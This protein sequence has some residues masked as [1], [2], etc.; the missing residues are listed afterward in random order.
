M[1][2]IPG[3][4]KIAL[5]KSEEEFNTS[6]SKAQGISFFFSYILFVCISLLF[7]LILTALLIGYI[8]VQIHCN[9]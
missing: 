4:S 8:L 2:L 3:Q 7:S 1:N 6:L 9:R 5:I